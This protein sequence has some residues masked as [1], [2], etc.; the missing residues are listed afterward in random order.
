MFSIKRGDLVKRTGSIVDVPAGKAMLGRVVDALGVPI[1]GRGALSDHERRRVE[2]KAPGIIECKSVHKHMQTAPTIFDSATENTAPVAALEPLSATEDTSPVSAGD[3]TSSSAAGTGS[4][5]SAELKDQLPDE[6]AP[7]AD[8]AAPIAGRGQ[9]ARVGSVGIGPL[10][11]AALSS[12]TST[13]SAVASPATA[14]IAV[15]LSGGAAL[16]VAA[17]VLEPAA[18]E[19]TAV[20]AAVLGSPATAADGCRPPPLTSGLPARRAVLLKSA[21]GLRCRS[22]SMRA[23]R[24]WRKVGSGS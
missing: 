5:T 12:T 6:A 14:S 17:A 11:R 18:M 21:M 9:R 10:P 4:S 13:P 7:I 15:A 22:K 23:E 16:T 19:T 1:D 20:A 24:A 3:M 8:E 2:V